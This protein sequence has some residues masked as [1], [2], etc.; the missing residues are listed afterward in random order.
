MVSW[1]MDCKAYACVGADTVY[2]SRDVN[3]IGSSGCKAIPHRLLTAR[4]EEVEALV[5]G[6]GERVEQQE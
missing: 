2:R 3:R 4:E 6:K 1:A 5:R